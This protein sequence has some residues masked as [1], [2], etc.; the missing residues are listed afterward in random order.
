MQDK[1]HIREMLK[2]ISKVIPKNSLL[3]F[4]AGANTK[5]NKTK[6][7]KLHYHYLTSNQRR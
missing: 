7:R 4:D 5:K 2:V 3:I 1:K 6:I